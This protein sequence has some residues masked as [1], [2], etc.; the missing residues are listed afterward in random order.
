MITT[1]KT[2]GI[3]FWAVPALAIGGSIHSK[4]KVT[5]QQE[6]CRMV[7]AFLIGLAIGASMFF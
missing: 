2:G 1:Q 7:A 3:T 6:R 4:A 5:I